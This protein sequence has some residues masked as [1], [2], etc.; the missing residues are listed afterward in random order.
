RSA[1]S[2]LMQQGF[3]QIEAGVTQLTDAG[4]SHAEELV[5][6]HRLWETYLVKEAGV[7]PA[8]VHDQAERLEHAH[9]LAEELDEELGKPDIDPH[10]SQIP[11]G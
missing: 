11:R 4:R 7:D 9:E 10:G 8:V 5:R 2:T 6:A 1:V 3:M